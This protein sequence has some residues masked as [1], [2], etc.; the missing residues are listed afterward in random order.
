[1]S[2]PVRIALLRH[3]KTAWNRAGRIQGRTD[4]PLDSEAGAA[5]A[6][7]GLPP[8]F[9]HFAVASSPLARASETAR[10]LTGDE[11]TIVPALAEMDWGRWEGLRGEDLLADPASGYRHVE[12]WGWDFQPP[13]GE[14]PR[15]L[16]LR[17]RSWLA[18]LDRDTLA[19]T[20]IGVMRVLMARAAGWDFSGP[21]PFAIKRRRLY[22]IERGEDGRL[23]LHGEP[24]RLREAV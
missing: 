3:E 6:R 8:G 1:M 18:T 14:T 19:V 17:L 12:D 15:R 4:I 21:C 24:V 20:H 7:L 9:E 2:R 23:A 10:L 13:G 5:L 16:W 22:V 11:P